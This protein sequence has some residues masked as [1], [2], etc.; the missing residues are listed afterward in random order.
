[1]GEKPTHPELLDHLAISFMKNGWSIK[2]MIRTIVLSKLTVRKPRRLPAKDPDNF[3]LSSMN[4]K[5]LNFEAMRDGM[6]Q[7]SGELDLTMHG[8]PKTP[9]QAIFKKKSSLWL[10]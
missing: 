5:R 3:Y 9:L 7:I 6:L 4:R 2:K 1:M 8:P 10:Y